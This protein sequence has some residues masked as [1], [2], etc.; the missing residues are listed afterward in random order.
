MG[1]IREQ[2]SQALA[3]GYCTKRNEHKILDPD[4]IADMTTEV[5][6]LD[7]V[8]GEE[9]I[10]GVLKEWNVPIS[11]SNTLNVE[12]YRQFRKALTHHLA[13]YIREKRGDYENN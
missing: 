11:T 5:L 10:E 7:G 3:R 8:V 6:A 1:A 2:L 9:E 4:L 12:Q 13:K